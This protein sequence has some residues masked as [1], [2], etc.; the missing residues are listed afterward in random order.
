ML[1]CATCLVA[2]TYTP[3]SP[4]PL[5]RCAQWL[6]EY[7]DGTFYKIRLVPCDPTFQGLSFTEAAECLYRRVGAVLIGVRTPEPL[8]TVLVNP[9]R[10]SLRCDAC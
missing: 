7:V 6:R 5:P 3:F 10:M 1:C 2:D 8:P 9:A 4:S